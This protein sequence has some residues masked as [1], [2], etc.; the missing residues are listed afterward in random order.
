MN[1]RHRHPGFNPLNYLIHGSGSW[2]RVSGVYYPRV[3][4]KSPTLVRFLI[5]KKINDLKS[6]L[7]LKYFIYNFW[8]KLN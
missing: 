1:Y 7:V 6:S 5:I 3:S 8:W 4:T 2:G